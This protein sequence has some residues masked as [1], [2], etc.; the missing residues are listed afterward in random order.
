M[1]KQAAGIGAAH[2]LGAIERDGALGEH[3]DA[4]QP[5]LKRAHDRAR[6]DGR[7]VDAH[8]LARLGALDQHAATATDAAL[9]LA[10]LQ[11]EPRQHGVGV[12]GAFDGLDA[13]V[14]DDHRLSDIERAE[15]AHDVEAARDVDH[16]VRLG[17][18]RAERTIADEQRGQ[19]VDRRDDL[20]ALAFEE[21]HDA[22]QHAIVARGGDDARYGRQVEKETEVRLDGAEIGPAHRADDDHLGDPGVAQRLQHAADL[23]P[24]HLGEREVAQIAVAFAD[25]GNDMHGSATRLDVLG[26]LARQAAAARHDADD[27]RCTR[28]TS[29]LIAKFVVSCR[30]CRTNFAI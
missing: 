17:L 15:R 19:H 26:Y 25:D 5:G 30:K 8:L 27:T 11:G 13:P 23:R 7:H 14:G 3:G 20:E 4:A 6:A 18:H 22:A 21:A 10:T 28:H 1:Y 2:Q 24:A 16:L 12:L 29:V 9:R